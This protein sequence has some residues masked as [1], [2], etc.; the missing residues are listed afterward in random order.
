MTPTTMSEPGTNAAAVTA[1]LHPKA[2]RTAAEAGLGE[3]LL[4]QLVL[5]QLHRLGDMVGTDLARSLGLQFSVIETTLASLRMMHQCEIIGSAA[6]GAPSYRYRI[7]DEGRR[8]AQLFLD[9]NQYSGVAPVPLAQYQQYLRAYRAATPTIS[10][11]DR[12]TKAF[13]HLVLSQRV[14]DQVGTAAAAGHSLFVYGPPGN[15]K[16]VIAQ[17]LGRLLE[18]EI[19]I[20]H[21]IE[22]DGHIVR[23]FDPVNHEA[24]PGEA[25]V[26]DLLAPPQLDARWIRC[27]RPM[28]TVGGELNLNSLDLSYSRD[29]GVY[30]PPIQAI[31]NG[32]VLVID[33]FGRQH[34]S[35][36]DLLN[37][38]IVPL[39]S[40]VDFLTLNNGQKFELPFLVMVVFATNLKPA[41]LVDEAFLR[42][43]Q[44]KVLAESPS[45]E[46]FEH[47]FE[48]CC[49]DRDLAYDPAFPR[50]IV[51]SFLRP[52][53]IQ[54]RGCHPRDLID[55]ALAYA[56]YTG[57]PRG[58]TADLLDEA[59]ASYFVDEAQGIS[60]PA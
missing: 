4:T 1:A 17:G 42:R 55:Q 24:L 2:P 8:R 19:A 46:D 38:W 57:R 15:G 49:R 37:R 21:A 10:T 28:V 53:N 34:C 35:P 11:R 30:T 45:F 33:D 26:D 60:T 51:E 25:P 48:N 47:I 5:K 39:E 9:Q 13:S 52:N 43:V 29:S 58:L 27:K 12:V 31:A 54:A 59:C 56:A 41:D 22:V 7:S 40:R 23:V 16:T 32:G 44:F 20:P 36:R 50:H 6:V 18:G 3:D 14:L